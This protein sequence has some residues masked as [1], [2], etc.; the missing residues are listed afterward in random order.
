M[1]FIVFH[2]NE[3]FQ[4]NDTWAEYRIYVVHVKFSMYQRISTHKEEAGSYSETSVSFYCF[5]T[6]LHPEHYTVKRAYL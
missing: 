1:T 2:S 5:D 3:Y 4:H 6:V